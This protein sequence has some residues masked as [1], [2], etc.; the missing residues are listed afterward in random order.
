MNNSLELVYESIYQRTPI[1]EKFLGLSG[2][3]LHDVYNRVKQIIHD[4]YGEDVMDIILNDVKLDDV[5]RALFD[6]IK[7]SDIEDLL[8]VKLI[9]KIGKTKNFCS[10]Y[11]LVSINSRAY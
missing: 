2:K 5:K 11:N 8:K 3:P 6:M 4:T 9:N 10:L 1:N 7:Q